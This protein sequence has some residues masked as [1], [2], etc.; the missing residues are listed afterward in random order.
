MALLRIYV[1]SYITN[2]RFIQAFPYM[3]D[4]YS[5]ECKV[6]FSMNMFVDI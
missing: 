6:F 4:I 1:L 5:V 3:C 2:A